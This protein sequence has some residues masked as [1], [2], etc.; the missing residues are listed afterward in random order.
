MSWPLS[1]WSSELV[2]F[3]S[4]IRPPNLISQVP[5]PGMTR[6]AR[7]SVLVAGWGVNGKCRNNFSRRR[8]R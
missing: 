4:F 1:C 8:R 3:P 6:E 7:I 5:A 2:F